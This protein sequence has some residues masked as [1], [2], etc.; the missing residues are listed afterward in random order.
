MTE[1][2]RI[3]NS[4]LPAMMAIGSAATQASASRPL[5][6]NPIAMPAHRAVTSEEMRMSSLLQGA[7]WNFVTLPDDGDAQFTGPSQQL[8]GM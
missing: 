1:Y 6:M 7:S 2:P 3:M 4:A 5:P 8:Q